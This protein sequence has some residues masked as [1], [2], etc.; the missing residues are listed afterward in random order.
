MKNIKQKTLTRSKL[1]LLWEEPSEILVF[2]L[3][4]D[5]V[6]L[7]L[8]PDWKIYNIFHTSFIKLYHSN[9]DKRFPSWKHTNP[10]PIPETDPQEDI[11]EVEVIQDYKILRGKNWYLVK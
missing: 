10:L 3:S 5:N 2:W 9:D 11:Y 7:Q 6:K 8:L 1:Q 4:I